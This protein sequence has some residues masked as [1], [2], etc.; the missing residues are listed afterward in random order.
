MAEPCGVIVG[1]AIAIT[2]FRAQVLA[3]TDLLEQPA[4]QAVE[5]PE[6]E[7]I[8]AHEA[9]DRAPDE[10]PDAG[11]AALAKRLGGTPLGIVAQ[12]LPVLIQRAEGYR[13]TIKSG[14]V[15]FEND[16]ATG[17]LPGRLLRGATA[18]PE[19]L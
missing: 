12:L 7:E 2:L 10:L 15:T 11:A 16:Q 4:V 18:V 1:G 5:Q 17:A 13:A 14:V 9:P 19:A 8:G 6:L 3:E